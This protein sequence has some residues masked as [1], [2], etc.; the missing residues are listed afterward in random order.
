MQLISAIQPH[1]ARQTYLDMFVFVHELD[2]QTISLAMVAA[3]QETT[4]QAIFHSPKVIK[5]ILTISCLKKDCPKLE[6]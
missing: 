5:N 4:V 3:W 2:P 6:V 1:K